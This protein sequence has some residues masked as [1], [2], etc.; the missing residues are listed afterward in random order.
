MYQLWYVKDFPVGAI[1]YS[2]K[3]YRPD[4]DIWRPSLKEN[5]E[6]NGLLNPLILWNHRN[7]KAYKKM[8]LKVGNNRLWAIKE[9][10]WV[11]VPC[12]IQ[13]PCDY[14]P[15]TFVFNPQVYFKDGTVSFDN[16]YEGLELLDATKPEDF[17]YPVS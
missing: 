5:I 15:K 6:K 14:E 16:Y 1:N 10:G 7:P 11:T 3:V 9:L 2:K 13:G 4:W 12:I 17:E 8:W